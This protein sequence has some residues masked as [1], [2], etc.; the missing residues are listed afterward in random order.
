MSKRLKE[1]DTAGINKILQLIASNPLISSE[2]LVLKAREMGYSPEDLIDK[3]LGSVK[4]EKS[5]AN[6]SKPLVDI[7]N[8]IYQDDPTPVNRYVL[9][10]FSPNLTSEKAK[11]YAEAFIDDPRL[12]GLETDLD[13]GRSRRLPY[14]VIVRDR[15]GDL[16]KL[17]GITVGGHELRHGVDSLIRPSFESQGNA[18][19]PKHHFGDIYETSELIREAKDLPPDSKVLKE[20]QKQA[21][22]NFLNKKVRPFTKL[23][24]LLPVGAGVAGLLAGAS[25]EDALADSVIPGGVERLGEGSDIAPGPEVTKFSPDPELSRASEKELKMLQEFGKGEI[26]ETPKNP[27]RDRM[28]QNLKALDELNAQMELEKMKKR[29]GYE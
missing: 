1:T 6:L 11:K 15:K 17:Q 2:E 19:Q 21:S 9:N 20:I 4:Y 28:E 13:L 23:M 5:G 29:M 24:G 27:A 8:E 14:D 16:P 22:K 10:P 26:V 12:L 25:A 3:A 18:F 7:L